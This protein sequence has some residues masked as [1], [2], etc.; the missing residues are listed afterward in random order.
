MFLNFKF[1]LSVEQQQH[2]Y[3]GRQAYSLFLHY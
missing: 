3:L 2:S 1:G